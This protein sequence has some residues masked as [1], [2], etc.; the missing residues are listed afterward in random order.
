MTWAR[1]A[2]SIDKQCLTECDPVWFGRILS[3]F[4][5]APYDHLGGVKWRKLVAPKLRILR[6][7]PT[8]WNIETCTQIYGQMRITIYKK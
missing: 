3:A 8:P 6:L 2:Y 5:E 7:D 4:R 1:S